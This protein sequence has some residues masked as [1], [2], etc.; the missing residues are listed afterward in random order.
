MET[1]LM[2]DSP[3][4]TPFSAQILE[5][6]MPHLMSLADTLSKR[7]PEGAKFAEAF[8][9]QLVSAPSQWEAIKQRLVANGLNPEL[10]KTWA[11]DGKEM[12]LSHEQVKAILGSELTQ[13]LSEKLNISQEKLVKQAETVLPVALAIL[14]EA[15]SKLQSS[16]FFK[17]ASTTIRG[18]FG[19][20]SKSSTTTVVSSQDAGQADQA[21][22]VASEKVETTNRPV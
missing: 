22:P 14:Q 16:S 5:K 7:F 19:E 12:I 18:F 4:Q 11:K 15:E 1:R 10:I 9:A 20:G 13:K 6:L 21:K 3:Q 2:T 17:W 8:V